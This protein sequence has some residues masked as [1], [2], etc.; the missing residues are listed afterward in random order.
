MTG[1]AAGITVEVS[2]CDPDGTSV[3]HLVHVGASGSIDTSDH[4]RESWVEAERVALALGDTTPLRQ[5]CLF[6]SRSPEITPPRLHEVRVEDWVVSAASDA[7]GVAHRT[8][9]A[10]L[11]INLTERSVRLDVSRAI[12]CLARIVSSN[13]DLL[14]PLVDAQ[15]L[16][17]G[18]RFGGDLLDVVAEGC[19]IR[20]AVDLLHEGYDAEQ[21]R[22]I[23]RALNRVPEF[24]AGEAWFGGYMQTVER[25]KDLGVSPA[26]IPGYLENRIEVLGP[27]EE[28][29]DSQGLKD[30]ALKR[31][32][33]EV[34]GTVGCRADWLAEVAASIPSA[35]SAIR[36][37]FDGDM[38]E[39]ATQ[40]HMWGSYAGAALDLILDV[41]VERL[42]QGIDPQNW[43]DK[44]ML[45]PA[46]SIIAR[47]RGVA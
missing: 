26:R 47:T 16:A 40:A 46:E 11:Q 22:R 27:P 44:W 19:T 10:A 18:D 23:V 31:L 32:H 38:M 4:E 14:N 43:P 15:T 2:C 25:L 24:Q 20:Q 37:Y 6:L 34:A 42:R 41:A 13:P 12:R 35:R 39:A 9:F 1:S 28:M 36:Y 30:A 7:I 29:R 5:P 21:S 45:P 17:E 3:R 8:F 33:A